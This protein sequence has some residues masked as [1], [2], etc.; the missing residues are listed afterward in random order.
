[1]RALRT[2]EF[3]N[4]FNLVLVYYKVSHDVTILSSH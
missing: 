3:L 4:F 2:A 1:M